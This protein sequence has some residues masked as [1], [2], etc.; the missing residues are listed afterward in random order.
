MIGWNSGDYAVGPF[1][2]TDAIAI[3]ILVGTQSKELFDVVQTVNIEMIHRQSSRILMHQGKSGAGD[4][5][6]LDVEGNGNGSCQRC[7]AGAQRANERDH[8]TGKQGFGD[9]LPKRIR[10]S[11]RRKQNFVR[12]A[13]AKSSELRQFT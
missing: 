11:K 4:Q 13:C 6:R 10:I 3:E 2:E 1:N 7:F 8:R 12:H 9:P 5:S